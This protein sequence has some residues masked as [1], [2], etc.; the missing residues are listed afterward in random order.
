MQAIIFIAVIAAIATLGV[1]YLSNDIELWV[2]EF[3]VGEGDILS[4][5][6]GSELTINIE[7]V[8]NTFGGFDDFIVSCGYVSLDVDLLAG[9]KL[10]CKLF[11]A[12]DLDAS[13]V[14]ATGFFELLVDV[15]A[16]QVIPITIDTTAYPKANKVDYVR[17]VLVEVQNP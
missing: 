2:Q 6:I 13:L 7:R 8:D 4:P 1:G 3:G 12:P 11:D 17:Q 14:I 10:F 16:G 9:T 15:P 5:V